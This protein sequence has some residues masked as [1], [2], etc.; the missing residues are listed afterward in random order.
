M[1]RADHLG[2]AWMKDHI[3]GEHTWIFRFLLS[4]STCHFYKLF[5]EAND[6]FGSK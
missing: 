5:S 6:R 4:S 3:L 1:E 2:A